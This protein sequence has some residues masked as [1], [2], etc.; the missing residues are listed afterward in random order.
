MWC[1]YVATELPI[2]YRKLVT[3]TSRC[4][5]I[6]AALWT[7]ALVT[8]S[9]P[10]LTKSNLIYYRYNANQKMCGLHWE[11]PAYC[12]IT[13]LYIPVLSGTV[14]IFTGL[15][16]NA[17]VRR[18]EN[19]HSR[20]RKVRAEVSEITNTMEGQS[21]ACSSPVT[22]TSRTVGSR[23]TLKILVCTSVTYFVLWTP[24][25]AIV[26]I[27]SFVSSFQPPSAV[28]FAVM[29]LANTN[30]A[31]DVFIYSSTNRQFRR[32]FLLLASRLCCSRLSYM[33][34]ALYGRLI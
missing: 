6:V 34:S 21:F 27:Q 18:R 32:Q 33:S 17:A 7:A 2:R 3:K 8:F 16:I 11:Y 26:F 22:Q 10:L 28:E 20:L 19:V 30:S 29:W 14:L 9:A 5:A 23:R 13:G 1:R 25:V 12:V 4:Y 24:Y 31:V 15:R